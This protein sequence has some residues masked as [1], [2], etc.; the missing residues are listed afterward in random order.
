MKDH[1]CQ[2]GNA[3]A[4]S[5]ASC[6]L[7]A[8]AR[9]RVFPYLDEYHRPVGDFPD[10]RVPGLRKV[11]AEATCLAW[12]DGRELQLSEA[13]VM[14]RPAEK[15]RAGLRGGPQFGP[16][17]EGFFRVNIAWWREFWKCGL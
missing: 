10:A 13:E 4:T 17:G 3:E 14:P 12:L 9:Q 8:A 1:R 15:R 5:H 16:H 2:C 6:R 11:L 7:D